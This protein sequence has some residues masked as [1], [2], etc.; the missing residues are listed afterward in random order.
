MPA[1][2]MS[3]PTTVPANLPLPLCSQ[4]QAQGCLSS[5]ADTGDVTQHAHLLLQAPRSRA[6]R[7]G[8]AGSGGLRASFK[9]VQGIAC[10]GMAYKAPR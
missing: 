4:P 8:Q 1:P 7:L 9:L 6:T 5:Q 10:G 3:W 2:A